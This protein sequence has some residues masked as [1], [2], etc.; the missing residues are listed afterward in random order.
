[1]VSSVRGLT[2]VLSLGL[3]VELP[4]SAESVPL[5]PVHNFLEGGPGLLV[6]LLSSLER[7]GRFLF[8]P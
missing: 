7:D 2:E 5:T 4:V 6:L 8:E 3:M 1:M